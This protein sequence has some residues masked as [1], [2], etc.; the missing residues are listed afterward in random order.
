MKRIAW[1]IFRNIFFFPYGLVRLWIVA[2]KKGTSTLEKYNVLRYITSKANKGGN[3]TIQ[4]YGTENI[5]DEDGY[6]IYPNHQGMY[7]VLAI[8]DSNPHPF[9]VVMKKELEKI[10]LLKS[11]FVA[12]EAISMDRSDVKQSVKVIVEVARRVSQEKK[13][14]LIFAEGTRSREGNKMGEMKGGSFKAAV[15]AQCPI[16]PVALID[17]YKPF[18]TNTISPATVYVRYLK[19]IPYEAYRDLSTAQIAEMVKKQIEQAI[20]EQLALNGAA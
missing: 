12:F 8:L 18:D 16:L 10:P 4:A 5:P 20:E 15:K 17:S 11:V 9:S 13:N 7:D 3:V 1:M 6:M 2:Y 14:Y 19:P